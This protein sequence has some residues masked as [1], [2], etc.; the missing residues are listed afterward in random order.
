LYLGGGSA[1]L[2]YARAEVLVEEAHEALVQEAKEYLEHM[3]HSDLL[4]GI[5]IRTQ[6][7]TGPPAQIILS[8]AQSEHADLIVLCS[9][10]YTGLKRW[11]LGSVA[12][13]IARHSP[14]PVVVLPEKSLQSPLYHPET[15]R[16]VRALVALDGSPLAKAVLLPTAQLVALSS[17]LAT[18]G[19]LH[20]MRVN[21]T[22]K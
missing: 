19:E 1:S 8:Y 16:A 12:Q 20:L 7:F 5:P 17:P 6:V 2:Y 15:A 11:A 4:E 10:G 14:V 9:H 18:S 22:F 13:K 3:A 21:Q